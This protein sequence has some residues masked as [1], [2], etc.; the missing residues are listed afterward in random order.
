MSPRNFDLNFSLAADYDSMLHYF[1]AHNISA[2]YIFSVLVNM[3][4]GGQ[5]NLSL[6]NIASK[7]RE[8]RGND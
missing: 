8:E 6:S 5:S 7:T 1:W 2:A 4:I 3:Q